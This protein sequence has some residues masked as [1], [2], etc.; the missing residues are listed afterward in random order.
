MIGADLDLDYA[1]SGPDY[2][3]RNEIVVSFLMFHS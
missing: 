2:N 1:D 3:S